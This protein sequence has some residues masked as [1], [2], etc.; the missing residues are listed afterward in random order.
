MKKVILKIVVSVFVFLITLVIFG[1]IMNRGNVN[2]TKD[3]D[4]ATFPV[5]T[6]NMSG[7]SINELHGYSAEMQTGLLRETITPLDENRGVSFR[8]SKYGQSVSKIRVEVR[9]TEG[10]RLIENIE[11]KDYDEDDYGINASVRLKDLIEQYCE[12]SFSV[13]LTI[14]GNEVMYHTNIIDAPNYCAHEKLSFV[15]DFHAKEASTDTN[16]ELKNYMESNYLGDNSTLSKVTIHSSMEQLAYGNLDVTEKTEPI[17]NIKELASETAI[18][19][20]NFI[21]SATDGEETNDYFVEE[22]Y[23]IKYTPEVTYLLDYERT[24]NPVAKEKPDFVKDDILS[25]GIMDKPIGLKESEDGNIIAF[26]QNNMLYSFNIN[27]NKLA[28][29]FSFY[30]SSNFDPRCYYDEHAIKVLNVDE[31]GNVWFLVY[32]YMNRGTYEGRVG[33]TLYFYN[34]VTSVIDECMFI[35]SDESPEMVRND[36]EE[37]SY[38]SKSQIFYFLLNRTIYAIDTNTKKVETLVTGLKENRYSVSDSGTMVVWQTGDDVN[39][40]DSIVVMNLNNKQADEIDAPVGQY[41]KPLAFVGEDFV[42]GLANMGD[43]VTDRAGRTTFPMYMMKIRSVYGETLKQYK[44]D[45]IY[46]TGVTVEDNLLTITRVSVASEEPLTYKTIDN[47]YMTSNKEEEKTSN[48]ESVKNHGYFEKIKIVAIKKTES[49]KTVCFTPQ[50]VIYEGSR[51]IDYEDNTMEMAYYYTYYKGK[52]Q[53][54]HTDPSAAVNEANKNYGTVLNANGKYVWYRANRQTRNQIMDLT[55]DPE[56]EEI[57][58]LPYCIEKLLEYEEQYK[59]VNYLLGKGNSILSILTENLED[60]N[61]LDLT[62]CPLD[63]ILYYVNRD[64]PV[65]VLLPENEAQLIIGYNQLAVV[66]LDPKGGARKI[67]MNEAEKLYEESG[68]RFISYVP[69]N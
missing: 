19:T 6:I 12:Y 7:H 67:G 49:T 50:E 5:I 4:K 41:I 32:G 29:L 64:I 24:M 39:A 31:G 34:G 33:A 61:V 59:N 36:I 30:D 46:V 65:L 44:E 55:F 8:I 60:C 43:V 27:E 69:N 45:G 47:D 22:Y 58:S 9:T 11:V 66:V 10:D 37:L 26:V 68:N 62:G 63:S 35:G 20:M 40:C 48:I 3:F 14:G 23:R 54:I 42:Y 38:F 2:T 51:E 57:E 28:K 56:E 21:I 15:C 13:F 17:V 16:Y 1:R 52:L 25:L 18:F 53:S